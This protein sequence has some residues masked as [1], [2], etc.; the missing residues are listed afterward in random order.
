MYIGAYLARLFHI[1]LF[2]K[3]SKKKYTISYN[4][5]LLQLHVHLLLLHLTTYICELS[6]IEVHTARTYNERV[7]FGGVSTRIDA[8]D[9]R[10]RTRRY[11]CS[12][13]VRDAKAQEHFRKTKFYT[14]R[15]AP[16]L[17]EALAV[18]TSD[19]TR[20]LVVSFAFV[21]D[22]PEATKSD[23]QSEKNSIKSVTYIILGSFGDY[24]YFE[25][26]FFNLKNMICMY[27]HSM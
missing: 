18:L 2:F 20:S 14:Y 11:V 3:H 13:N 12:M 7:A 24:T 15:P 1:F 8:T 25:N 10:E 4:S 5:Y 23:L 22:E 9:G 17:N 6:Q 19:K 16:N 27:I 21:R 26:I